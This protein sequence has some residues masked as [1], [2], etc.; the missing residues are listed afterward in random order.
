MELE[1]DVE[2]IYRALDLSEAIIN[3][4]GKSEFTEE[5]LERHLRACEK[6]IGPMSSS[7]VFPDGG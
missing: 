2:R 7:F 1:S 4:K 3:Q 5:E 6:K